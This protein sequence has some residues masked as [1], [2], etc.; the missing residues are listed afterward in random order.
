[1]PNMFINNIY[2]TFQVSPITENLNMSGHPWYERYQVISYK[3]ITRCG[4]EADFR[5]MV[6]RC[7]NA[8][9]R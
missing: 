9:V 4:N 1:M 3:I 2:F 7:N 5:D 6:K 8:G